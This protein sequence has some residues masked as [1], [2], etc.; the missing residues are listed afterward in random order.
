MNN[1][2]KLDGVFSGVFCNVL[3]FIDNVFEVDN[4]YDVD[5]VFDVDNVLVYFW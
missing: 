1:F 5:N 4:V 2:F 3:F